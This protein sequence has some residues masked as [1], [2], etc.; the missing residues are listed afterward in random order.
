[1]VASIPLLKNKSG[2]SDIL[3]LPCTAHTLQLAIIKGLASA[4]ILVARAR[5]LINFFQYQKQVERLEQ[6]QRKLGYRDIL[7][8]I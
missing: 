7:R 8:C 5:R 6:V 2:C 3:R 4:E 1:M